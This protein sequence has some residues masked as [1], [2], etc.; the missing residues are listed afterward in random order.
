MQKN[1]DIDADGDSIL[2]ALMD[3]AW[4]R[5]A[6]LGHTSS[7]EVL[8]STYKNNGTI[9]TRVTADFSWVHVLVNITL[10]DKIFVAGSA[11]TWLAERSLCSS[12][13]LWSPN[14]I[15]VFMCLTPSDYETCVSEFQKLYNLSSDAVVRRRDIVDLTLSSG[16]IVS[17][18]R[19]PINW[20]AQE[21]ISQFDI[22]ICTPI[23]VR[24]AD[25]GIWVSM[26][27][28]VAAGIRERE[29][30]CTVRKRNALF[31]QYPLQ[32]SLHRMRKYA[33]RGYSFGALIFEATSHRDFP[34]RDADSELKI[35]DF[36]HLVINPISTVSH[37]RSQNEALV[38]RTD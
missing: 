10:S 20:G 36:D 25:N 33:A 30:R 28:E 27:M 29:M 13:P 1:V 22:N 32:K 17:F 38:M 35:S 4:N 3:V 6:D 15:D 23:I 7:A 26:S 16:L 19:C 14:D 9:K 2:L 31:M 5:L 21:V 37:A 11:A 24:E 34:D 18:I 8:Y 12:T